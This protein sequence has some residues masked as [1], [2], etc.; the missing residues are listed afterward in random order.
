MRFN[1]TNY[2][3]KNM[4]VSYIIQMNIG[5]GLFALI[6]HGAQDL[7]FSHDEEDDEDDEDELSNFVKFSVH[8]ADEM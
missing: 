5:G 7:L 6:A 8:L 1:H 4:I 2:I 3:L